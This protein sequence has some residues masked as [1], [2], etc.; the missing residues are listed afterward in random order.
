VQI[1]HREA[2]T[3]RELTHDQRLAWLKEFL[4][5]DTDTL[6]Y[7]VAG[8]LL[9]LYA[10]PLVR[11]ATLPTTAIVV[12]PHELRIALGKEPPPV[13]EPFAG[14]IRHHLN[15]RP[16]L[17][18]AGGSVGT[19]WLFPGSR[20]GKH[21]D[22]QSIMFRL[23]KLGINLL[24]ARNAAIQNLVA[25]VPLPWSPNSSL[26][27]PSHSP[28]R[29]TRSPAMVELRHVVVATANDPQLCTGTM[30]ASIERR[31]VLD[32]THNLPREQPE[33]FGASRA[34][35]CC[36][37]QPRPIGDSDCLLALEM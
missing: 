36:Q 10:Q 22:P 30:A 25:E 23:R 21:L 2:K 13:T 1:D 29:R 31:Q 20:A 35:P 19:P 4:Q 9:L 11:V 37:S 14:M 12:T 16:N 34:R 28:P 32:A 33:S 3:T 26:Q 5:G 27:L 17:R 7:R 6:S 8:T 24:G 18:T 15:N